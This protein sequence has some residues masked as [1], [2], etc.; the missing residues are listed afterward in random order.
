MAKLT[1][2]TSGHL[3]MCV[4][5]WILSIDEADFHIP[6]ALSLSL[7]LSHSLSVSALSSENFEGHSSK[8]M[9]KYTEISLRKQNDKDK[10][11]NWRAYFVLAK[12]CLCWKCDMKRGNWNWTM[13]GRA[14]QPKKHTQNKLDLNVLAFNCFMIFRTMTMMI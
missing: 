9:S 12:R 13:F 11:S 14:Y 8:F 1:N 5:I 7:S 2:F 4:L 6:P 3:K 10:C